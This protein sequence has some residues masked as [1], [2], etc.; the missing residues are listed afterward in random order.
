MQMIAQQLSVLALLATAHGLPSQW[1]SA[2]VKRDVSD[3]ANEYDYIVGQYD[4]L[5]D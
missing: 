5:G 1:R 2:V 4:Q 3:L